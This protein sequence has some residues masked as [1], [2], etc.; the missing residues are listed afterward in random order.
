MP[1]GL[2]PNW[3][4]RI[5]S[6]RYQWLAHSSKLGLSL[7]CISHAVFAQPAL[8]RCVQEL[9]DPQRR[10]SRTLRNPVEL[11]DFEAAE[12]V[13]PQRQ[14]ASLLRDVAGKMTEHLGQVAMAQRQ[15]MHGLQE[16]LGLDVSGVD[17]A[18]MALVQECA[19]AVEKYESILKEAGLAEM[20]SACDEVLQECDNLLHLRQDRD[21]AVTERQHYEEKLE[22]LQ[23]ASRGVMTEQI[24]RNTD[25][26]NKAN[27]V[28]E[29]QERKLAAA[30]RVFMYRRP[31][32]FR[33]MFLALFRKYLSFLT[34]TLKSIELN[35]QLATVVDEEEGGA[36]LLVELQDGEQKSVRIENLCPADALRLESPASGSVAALA[37]APA[38]DVAAS[39]EESPRRGEGGRLRLDP[40]RVPCSGGEVEVEPSCGEIVLPEAYLA[41]R[42]VAKLSWRPLLEVALKNTLGVFLE[43][44][45]D[46]L[47]ISIFQTSGDLAWGSHV[48]TFSHVMEA[49]EAEEQVGLSLVEAAACSGWPVDIL[50]DFC[51]WPLVVDSP[52]SLEIDGQGSFMN[53]VKYGNHSQA[54]MC[55]LRG[56]LRK[57]GL[58]DSLPKA[59]VEACKTQTSTVEAVLSSERLIGA[60]WCKRR[61]IRGGSLRRRLEEAQKEVEG[62]LLY[63]AELSKATKRPHHLT[64]EPCRTLTLRDVKDLQLPPLGDHEGLELPM[65]DRGHSFVGGRGVGSCLHVDQAWWSNIAKNYTGYKLVAVWSNC[66]VLQLKGQL[67]RR[68]LSKEQTDAL[69]KWHTVSQQLELVGV[70]GIS[71]FRAALLAPPTYSLLAELEES[72]SGFDDT[73]PVLQIAQVV[74]PRVLIIAG[75]DSGGGAG[76]QADLKSCAA[77][78]AFSTT[79]IT[80]LTAQNTHGVQGIFPILGFFNTQLVSQ[81]LNDRIL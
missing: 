26:L 52:G 43:M 62:S 7:T 55:V 40:P 70:L 60:S 69:R 30:L 8:Q 39:T 72:S 2:Q 44:Q 64:G 74:P 34:Q 50:E 81:F 35:G 27:R 18:A 58:S 71:A 59:L 29:S 47:I 76:L 19:S 61:E 79:A 77:L 73:L 23:A 49:M 6:A 13:P 32:H 25:K 14:L 28:L 41:G 68:P 42:E 4:R 57:L 12:T 38:A 31:V 46:R 65:W 16:Y 21:A 9:L 17:V 1:T 51:K 67:F 37:A 15:L 5:E 24:A 22:S 20:Q 54:Q 80:A 11:S 75:S 10:R 3:L 33:Q 78:G 45:T 36:R 48:A 53:F 66:D 56:G 63:M